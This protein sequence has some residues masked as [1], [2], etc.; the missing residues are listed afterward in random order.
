[1]YLPYSYYN[2]AGID[3]VLSASDLLAVLHHFY[4]TAPTPNE[5]VAAPANAKLPSSASMTAGISEHHHAETRPRRPARAISA[6]PAFLRRRPFRSSQNTAHRFA[7]DGAILL[8]TK[9][10]RQV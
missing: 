5:R 7:A 8:G 1:M 6:R 9:F 4:P 3:F 2:V 10:F